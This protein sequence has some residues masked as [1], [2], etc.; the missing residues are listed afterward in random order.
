MTEK[1]LHGI[2][3]YHIREVRRE[4]EFP[5]YGAQE[6]EHLWY[7]VSVFV[8]IKGRAKSETFAP[9]RLRNNCK[10]HSR[11]KCRH[12]ELES[13]RDGAEAGGIDTM[14]GWPGP[15]HPC[16]KSGPKNLTTLLICAAEKGQISLFQGSG[17]R[18]KE[19]HLGPKR[20]N[21][22]FHIGGIAIVNNIM[23]RDLSRISPGSSSGPNTWCARMYSLCT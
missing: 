22:V 10:V 12:R 8:T 9:P 4:S 5:T 20:Q 18:P 1:C 13:G 7:E 15:V 21:A 16:P 17:F 2:A 14:R 3:R 19:R 23:L 11:P 6:P